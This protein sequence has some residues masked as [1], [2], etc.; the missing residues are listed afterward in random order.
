MRKNLED[1]NMC[2]E[3]INT[4]FSDLSL[5][6][7][8]KKKFSY[9]TSCYKNFTHVVIIERLMTKKKQRVN[10]CVF[11][12][13]PSSTIY[14]LHQVTTDNMFQKI[15]NIFENCPELQLEQSP[16]KRELDNRYHLGCLMK[17]SRK[18]VLIEK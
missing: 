1:N 6:Q 7:L 3:R 10:F 2:V 12:K 16:L 5:S 18:R 15:C 11:C 14:S 8:Y 13:E 9:H 17:Y 4:F